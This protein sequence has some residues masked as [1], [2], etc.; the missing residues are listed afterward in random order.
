ME[1]LSA[2]PFKRYVD[3]LLIPDKFEE[4]VPKKDTSWGKIS[5]QVNVRVWKNSQC[6]RNYARVFF[7]K[8]LVECDNF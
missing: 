5:I 3:L 7:S 6:A 4:E 2:Q 1:A 8:N